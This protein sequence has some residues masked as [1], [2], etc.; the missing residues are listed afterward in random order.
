MKLSN[1]I[2]RFSELLDANKYVGIKQ[3][4]VF[5]D[6]NK[7]ILNLINDS[8][9]D[10]EIIMKINR[11]FNDKNALLK[12]NN[13]KYLDKKLIE[14]KDYFDDLFLNVDKNIKLDDNQRQA[15][16]A[17][18]DNLLIV[19]GAG[20][21]K[22]TTM[23]A[24]AKYLVD[25]CGVKQ[26]EIAVVSFTKK[27]ADEIAYRINEQFGLKDISVYTFHGL[28]LKIIRNATNTP[29]NIIDES[30][31]YQVLSNY[32]KNVLFKDKDLF[33]KF[34][35]VFRNKTY[36]NDDWEKF[37]TF[38]EYHNHKYEEKLNDSAFDLKTYNDN[39][40]LRRRKYNKSI[41]GEYLKSHEEVDIANYL[42]KNGVNYEYEKVYEKKLDDNK[43][44]KPDFYIEQLENYNYIEHFGVDE[45]FQNSR[46]SEQELRNYLNNMKLKI[47][48]H[49]S[50]D[51]YKKFFVTYSKY[52]DG[53]NYIEHLKNKLVS[54]GYFL[55]ERDEK[56]IFNRLRD[57][58][59]D[60][61]FASLID[62]FLIPFI[63][64]FK[65]QNYSENDFSYFIDIADTD[66]MRNELYIMKE[67][68]KYYQGYLRENCRIDFDDMI[69]LA[70]RLIPKIKESDLGIDYNY[71]I[72]DE[73]QD[74]S[75]QRY[76][77]TKRMS[78]L[79]DAKIFAVGD[80]WQ[81][82]FGFAGSDINLF[83]DFKHYLNGA[84]MIPITNTY[85]NGQE[86]IDIASEFV[87]KNRNQIEKNL[88]SFKHLANPVEIYRY[89]D[90]SKIYSNIAK[91]NA[92]L[93]A[94]ED[95]YDTNVNSTVLLMGRYK[96]D[97]NFISG[98]DMFI[99][100]TSEK[101][102]CKKYPNMDITFLTI[103]R[104]KGLG[105]DNCILLNANDS[106]YGFPSKI[107]D[108]PLIKIIKPDIKEDILYPEERRLFY[109]AL[110]RT[111]NKVYILAP[112]TDYS[113]FI[114]ELKDYANVNF[115][116]KVV[117]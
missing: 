33:R 68:Y 55:K 12:N 56:E 45:N 64:L 63:S 81:S 88:H 116:D 80:D 30:G 50:Q 115:I 48:Y 28:G 24:K 108:D 86:L 36:F 15:I 22:T 103:H 46:Y 82:I 49:N 3:Y 74:V 75:A 98:S 10:E 31:K 110:T 70:Y 9:L 21:G 19:A 2:L 79:F 60:G 54:N 71:I 20:S 92:L 7:D 87:L 43:T 104:S 29:Y 89:N 1:F 44:Y 66:F 14:Y 35:T 38:E 53:T 51:N 59:Q 37:D 93:L 61:Y 101:I 90:K 69:N 57:T 40:I 23:A 102:I 91:Q 106:T 16:V 105:F 84:K 67:I 39:E 109:V 18:E 83:T 78:D 95:I 76:N 8:S 17:D 5:L 26:S 25:K 32:I 112:S 100:K 85:R 47:N 111:K 11:I 114:E 107:I 65:S 96:S 62:K 4:D 99:K 113:S 97:I 73:Y 13:M 6:E 41:N 117:N 27:A 77:L 42:Y 94:I 72:I 34:N 52:S 58:S